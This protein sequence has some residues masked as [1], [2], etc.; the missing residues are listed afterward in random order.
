MSL[1]DKGYV[2][3]AVEIADELMKLADQADGDREDYR[4][5]I[6]LGVV[7]DCA[8]KIRKEAQRHQ[9]SQTDWTGDIQAQS[10]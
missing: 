1:G 8:Y 4:C 5:G 7:R 2:E 6:F 9:E 3:K 10:G